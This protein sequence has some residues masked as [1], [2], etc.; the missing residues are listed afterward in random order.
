V[1]PSDYEYIRKILKERSGYVLAP[2]KQYLIDSRLLPVARQV[3]CGSITDLVMKM[4]AP[5]AEA[6]LAKVTEAMTINESFFFRDKNP[7][8]RFKDTMLP[9]IMQA[10]AS[11]RR[12]RIWCAAASTGQEP[13]SIAMILKSMSEKLVGW[14]IEIVATDISRDV[15]ERARAGIY[16]Q[17]EVQ[18]GL[19]IQMLMQFF[20]QVGEQWR[21]KDDIRKM[22]Q[23]RQFN[24]LE[25]FSALG[26]FDVVFCRNVLIYFDQKTKSDVL[27][28]IAQQLT[29]EGFLVLGAAETV[30]G[31]S[32]SF[33]PHADKRGLYVRGPSV[34][35]RLAVMPAAAAAKAVV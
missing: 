1:T 12:M 2:D 11:T 4:R 35:P 8:D 31:L 29:P 17:F 18:R 27:E 9:A 6:L 3:E 7:F 14:N 19:P 25:R 26:T 32:E 16:S 23:F 24:L 33:K 22:V 20:E 13:Y 34:R 10:R 15:L 21:V 5:N 28:R 30:V